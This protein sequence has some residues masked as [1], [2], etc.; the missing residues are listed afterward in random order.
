MGLFCDFNLAY[1]WVA[2]LESIQSYPH[3]RSFKY[4]DDR[5]VET[6]LLL[7]M[8]SLLF[9]RQFNIS[10]Q[11]TTVA[12]GSSDSIPSGVESMSGP[13]E[14]GDC[15]PHGA[16]DVVHQTLKI[17]WPISPREIVLEREFRYLPPK[18]KLSRSESSDGEDID[19][20][21]TESES[22]LTG[23]LLESADDVEGGGVVI[24]RYQSI[25]DD[26]IPMHPDRVRAESPLTMWRFQ[27]VTLRERGKKTTSLSINCPRFLRIF[28]FTTSN[29]TALR[30]SDQDM[31]A[32]YTEIEVQV[33]VDSKGY[34]PV[35]FINRIQRLWPARAMSAFNKLIK[36]KDSTP[37]NN[38]SDVCMNTAYNSAGRCAA[39][40]V[41]PFQP[42]AHW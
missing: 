34:I 30:D 24:V 32:K 38:D 29:T 21:V 13:N 36:A 23:D 19:R 37:Q 9:K 2:M 20:K 35:W 5:L 27:D 22:S 14:Y 3:V 26:R 18:K 17:P 11:N 33:L 7:K 28:I 25:E 16:K 15:Q 4:T 1:E 6:C 39:Q 40:G 42:V 31:E 41:K 8:D 10:S 12:N